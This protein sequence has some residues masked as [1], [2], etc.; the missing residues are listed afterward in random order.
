MAGEVL[1]TLAAEAYLVH[2]VEYKTEELGRQ[3]P[4][5]E[6]QVSKEHIH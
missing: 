2:T 1:S 4:K 3:G 6:K 5:K